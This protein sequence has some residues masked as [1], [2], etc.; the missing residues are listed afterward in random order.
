MHFTNPLKPQIS[1]QINKSM[2]N[3]NGQV[4]W[5]WRENLLKNFWKDKKTIK[6]SQTKDIQLLLV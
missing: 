5:L 4:I 3:L 2:K 1:N 6:G